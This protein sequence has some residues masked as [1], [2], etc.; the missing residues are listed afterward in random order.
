MLGRAAYEVLHIFIYKVLC[1]DM[2]SSVC[3][4]SGLLLFQCF[5]EF[6]IHLLFN[7]LSQTRVF[8]W[9][10]IESLI[11]RC[12]KSLPLAG[13]TPPMFVV[14]DSY[15]GVEKPVNFTCQVA[16]IGMSLSLGSP[17]LCR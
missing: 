9:S 6:D 4:M 7:S 11:E 8:V 2:N 17:R 5:G 15:L 12:G 13:S 16:F 14:E 10:L 1:M 3:L